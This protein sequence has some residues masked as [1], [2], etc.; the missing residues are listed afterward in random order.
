ME[1]DQTD[2]EGGLVADLCAKI[3]LHIGSSDKLQRSMAKA[4]RQPPA[5][6]AFIRIAGTK[7]ADAA[8]L[9]VIRFDLRGP[10]QGHFWYVRSLVVGSGSPTTG[11]AGRADVYIV[12]GGTPIGAGGL[13]GLGLGDWRDQSIALPNVSFYGRGEMPLRRGEMLYVVVSAGTS[14][15]QYVAGAQVEDFDESPHRQD[16]DV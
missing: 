6:P 9:A 10:D 3:D 13:A 14:G 16:W 7:I 12:A 11:A 2:R 15:L 1:L 8:G 4:L 5:Q